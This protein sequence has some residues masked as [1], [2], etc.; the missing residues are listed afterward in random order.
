M[1]TSDYKKNFKQL[2][3]KPAKLAKYIKHNAPKK[4]N[5]GR[6]IKKCDLCGRNGGYIEKLGICRQCFRDN[7]KKLGFKKY[8]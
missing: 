5:F 3:V 2:E 6:G 4:R 1:T 8:M 7:A